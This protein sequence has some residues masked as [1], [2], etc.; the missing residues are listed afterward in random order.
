MTVEASSR[1][2]LILT[3]RLKAI[4]WPKDVL[5]P[6][7]LGE[8][9]MVPEQPRFVPEEQRP[10][11]FTSEGWRWNLGRVRFFYNE[12]KRKKPIEPISVI[13]PY[14]ESSFGCPAVDD[15]H[16]RYVAYVFARKL[17]IPIFFTGPDRYLGWLRGVYDTFPHAPPRK[18]RTR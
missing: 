15:G 5:G 11:P 4:Y 6:Y 1:P 2:T 9:L 16:H 17:R 3:K 18:T 13:T 12:L 8:M 10:D 14:T 7:K